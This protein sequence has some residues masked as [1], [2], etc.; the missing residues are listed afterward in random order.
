[1]ADQPTSDKPLAELSAAEERIDA[2]VNVREPGDPRPSDRPTDQPEP[3]GSAVDRLRAFE[4]KHFGKDAVRINDRIERGSG[5]PYQMAHPSVREQHV[6]LEKLI[7]A[8]Q[9]LAVAHAA[10]IQAD[11]EHEQAQQDVADAE[12]AADAPAEQ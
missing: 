12:K 8:E 1:M 11:T 4:D 2:P 6:K 3:E 7:Q 5:S 9:K 10:L